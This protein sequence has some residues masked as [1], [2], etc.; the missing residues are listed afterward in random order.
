MERLF[1]N[2]IVTNIHTCI[3]VPT[4][5]EAYR[6][7]RK[8]G[9]CGFLF[10]TEGRVLYHEGENL[11]FTDPGHFIFV[12]K[13]SDYYL[14]G[15][16]N[17]L[18]PCLN[19]DCNDYP[20]HIV[21]LPVPN[22]TVLDEALRLTE[23]YS[24][25]LPCYETLIRAGIYRIIGAVCQLQAEVRL[26]K[27]VADS[28][29]YMIANLSDPALT[30]DRIAAEANISAVYLSKEFV[31]YLHVSPHRYLQNR[32]IERAKYLLSVENASITETA[33]L[34]GYNS[35]YHFSRSFKALTG[36]PPTKYRLI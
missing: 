20:D 13:G 7:M 24:L 36:I 26:P 6:P 19:F 12:P 14:T 17:D 27:H 23:L 18:C 5:P 32:R 1:E 16:R 10:S 22:R 31:K 21:Q 2:M 28:I 29:A 33:A 3:T 15:D 34:V 4:P 9:C 30:N 8:R 35:V 11:T 25:K